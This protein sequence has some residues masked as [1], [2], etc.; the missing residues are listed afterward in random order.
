MAETSWLLRSLLFVPGHR[1]EMI[2]K[3][4]ASGADAIIM[5]LEDGVAPAEK[6]AARRAVAAALDGPLPDRLVVFVRLNSTGSGRLDDDV[7]EALRARAD[8]VCL[9]KCESPADVR[10]VAA[11]LLAAEDRLALPRGRLRMLAL[12]ETA[13]G[14]I[15]SAAI[16]RESRRVY[17][18]V[19]GAEDFTADT[20]MPRTRE[21]TELAAARTAVSLA[22]H[23]AGVDAIDGI[24]ADFR[25]ADGLAHDTMEARRLGYTG[26]TL[27]HPAQ[28]PPVHRMFAPGP[29]EITKAR[30]IVE[31]FERGETA[32]SGIVVVD[33]AMVD[34]PVVLRAQRVL[35]LAARGESRSA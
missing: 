32:G 28:I 9:P 25:D 30:R 13:R 20:G 2:A 21:G 34:R 24:F 7:R 29:D 35:A 15:A 33:G 5:D 18:L 23:A 11:R 4:A 6:P 16:A 1:H 12:V 22:A 17:G 3:A 26:K 14:V 31:A 19:F 10:A 27:I 8:G